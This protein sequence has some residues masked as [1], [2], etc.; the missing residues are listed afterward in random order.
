MAVVRR[1]TWW[2]LI[3]LV[4]GALMGAAVMMYAATKAMNATI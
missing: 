2:L 4:I 1:G 3:A